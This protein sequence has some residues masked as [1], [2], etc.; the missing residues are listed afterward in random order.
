LVIDWLTTRR[1]DQTE[2]HDICLGALTGALADLGEQIDQI[3][4]ARLDGAV[5]D[6]REPG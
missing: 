1:L 2:L 5:V 3:R 6:Q 4:L